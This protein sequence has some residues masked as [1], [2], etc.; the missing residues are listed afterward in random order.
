MNLDLIL[1]SSFFKL[2]TSVLICSFL[3]IEFFEAWSQKSFTKTKYTKNLF[4]I[5][6]NIKNPFRFCKTMFKKSY[7]LLCEFNRGQYGNSQLTQ[8]WPTKSGV[9][10]TTKH[11]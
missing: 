7:D 10:K 1:Y 5:I 11:T 3:M 4:S 2:C 9:D 8:V 6:N